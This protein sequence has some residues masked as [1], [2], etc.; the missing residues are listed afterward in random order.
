MKDFMKIQCPCGCS[1]IKN[2]IAYLCSRLNEQME[3]KRVL[4]F[5]TS[6]RSGASYELSVL[7]YQIE[8]DIINGNIDSNRIKLNHRLKEKM[9]EGSLG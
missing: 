7:C 5:T 6:L 8:E 4:L 3:K 9:E 1:A 2:Y